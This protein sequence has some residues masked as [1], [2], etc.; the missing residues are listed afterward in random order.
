MDLKELVVKVSNTVSGIVELLVSRLSL[1][2]D[3]IHL[4]YFSTKFTKLV[5]KN[6]CLVWELFQID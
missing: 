1:E 4:L 6:E 5:Q 3:N 2:F